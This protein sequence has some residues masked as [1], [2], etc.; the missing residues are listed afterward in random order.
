VERWSIR[1]SKKTGIIRGT[2][3][4]GTEEAKNRKDNPKNMS[5]GEMSIFSYVPVPVLDVEFARC[6]RTMSPI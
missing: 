2:V 6:F 1:R 5:T 4:S 3:G